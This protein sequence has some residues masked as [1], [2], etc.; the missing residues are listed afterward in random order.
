VSQNTHPHRPLMVQAP[1]RALDPDGMAVVTAGTVAFAIGAVVCWVA[2]A[3][4]VAAGK[5]WYFWV[6]VTGTV[7]GLVGLA[8]GLFRKSRR[9]RGRPVPAGNEPLMVER[10][11]PGTPPDAPAVQAGRQ[12]PTDQAS[13]A[14]GTGSAGER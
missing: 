6:S 2:G 10:I 7:L 14:V 8:F 13:P 4:L 1:V 3:G 11:V 9:N 5:G 12:D